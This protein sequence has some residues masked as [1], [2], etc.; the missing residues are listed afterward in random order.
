VTREAT[1]E[2]NTLAQKTRNFTNNTV[3]RTDGNGDPNRS[4]SFSY[5]DRRQ[6][7]RR[8]AVSRGQTQM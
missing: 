6:L 4:G 2:G 7:D 3:H 1:G 8:G 5:N